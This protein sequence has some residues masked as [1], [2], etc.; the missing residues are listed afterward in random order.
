MSVREYF[1]H[2]K[3]KAAK[4]IKKTGHKQLGKES[5][6]NFKKEERGG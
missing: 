2:A 5:T 6:E 1:V 3:E 4:G